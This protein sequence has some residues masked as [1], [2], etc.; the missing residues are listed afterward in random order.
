MNKKE[1]SEEQ[2]LAVACDV[3]KKA[4]AILKAGA[5]KMRQINFEDRNDVKL[6]A[7]IESETLIRKLFGELADFPVIGEE[8]G[9]D[10]SLL[11]SNDLFWIVDPLDGTFNYLRDIPMTCVSIGLW[12]GMKP[13]LG[14]IY[15]FNRDELFSGISGKGLY[16]N[17]NKVSPSWATR[18]S[19]AVLYTGFPAARDLSDNALQGFIK[20][21][22]KYKK[23][24]M[25]GSAASAIAAVVCGRGD[26]YQEDSVRLWDIAAG[27]ALANAAGAK[28]T[29]EVSPAAKLAYNV[30]V[31]G[32]D[33]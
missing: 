16:I 2:L 17:G 18:E 19:Q 33:F 21:V 5:D 7:D 10:E 1:F 32:F 13:V 30:R 15:D 8:K 14:V 12:R 28:Y 24:R 4:G 26:V 23:V 22:Q 9:G 3:A 11:Q 31:T 6:Q 27:L 20:D 25:V 29:M